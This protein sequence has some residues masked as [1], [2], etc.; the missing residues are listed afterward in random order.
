MN[1]LFSIDSQLYKVT[2]VEKVML[3][4]HKAVREDYEAK[5]VGNIPYNKIRSEHGI[6]EEEYIQFKNPFMFYNSIVV[7]HERR[8]LMLFWLLNHLLFQ[9]LLPFL[10]VLRFLGI[11]VIQKL[12]LSQALF[13]LL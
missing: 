7:V 6:K 3:N 5:I 8:L 11:Q 10:I 9:L 12:C 13:L 1:K 4:I 2:G